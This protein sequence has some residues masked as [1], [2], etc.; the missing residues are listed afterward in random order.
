[1]R[2]FQAAGVPWCVATIACLLSMAASSQTAASHSLQQ[3]GWTIDY[4]PASASLSISAGGLGEVAQD[5]QF[6]EQTPS[7]LQRLTQFSAHVTG[8]HQ[9][10][11]RS[12]APVTTWIVNALPGKVIIST[13]SFHG[14]LRGWV[15]ASV[16]RTI[17]ILLDPRGEPV[18]WEGTEE[19]LTTYGGAVTSNLSY[20]PRLHPEVMHMALGQ[21]S[22]AGMHSL[23][24]RATDT[25][26]DFGPKVALQVSPNRKD[27]Y[28]LTIPVHGYA[29]IQLTPDY[30]TRILHVPFYVRYD[31]TYFPTAPAVWSSW[32]I[33]YEHATEQDIIR[34]TDWLA[35]NLRPYGFEYVVLDDG[36]D[37]TPYFGHPEK[38]DHVPPGETSGHAWIQN[39][40]T[41]RFTHGPQWLTSYIH[42]KGLKAGVWLVPNVY[43]LALKDH[44]DWYLYDKQGHVIRDYDTPALDSSNPQALDFLRHLFSTLDKFGFDYYKF[45]GESALPAYAPSVDRSRLYSPS[46][47]LVQA[48]RNRF[49]AIRQT[50][51]LKRFI[52]ECPA[53][54]PLNAIGFV[55][56]YFNGQDVFENW[57][58]MYPYFSSI[59]GN[60]FLNHMVTYVMPGE[61]MALSTLSTMVQA[62][63]TQSPSAVDALRARDESPNGF[64]TTLAEARTLV[65]YTS[66]TGVVYAVGDVMPDLP[67]DRVQLLRETMP[68]LPILPI[69]LFSRGTEKNVF[70]PVPGMVRT[71]H[72]PEVLDLKINASAGIYDVVAETNWGDKDVDRILSFSQLGLP[73]DSKFVVFDFWNQQP[74][75]VF[76]NQ[77][78][79]SIEP[80]DTRVLALHP[81]VQHPQLIGTSRHISGTYSVLSQGWDAAA[82]DL[83]GESKTIPSVLYTLWFYLPDGY[84]QSSVQVTSKKGK[85]VDARWQQQGNFGSLRFRGID[86]P[87]AWRIAF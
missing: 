74:L 23:F 86:E 13:T 28:A 42:A 30:F 47:D 49:A 76:S 80:H 20:L 3:N 62:A 14:V 24:D 72:F 33:Y 84:R 16:N 59:T 77:L 10:T 70:M 22:G 67:P 6:N 38:L 40:S 36:Y 54:T 87:V 55:N 81:I 73:L 56:S 41:T 79:L 64:G 11:L 17:A 83:Y 34:N 52:E 12:A 15:P 31:D 2:R 60:L 44:P 68:T 48:F 9:L 35:A 58:G 69:D 39:W 82:K 63:A 29:T 7:G 27:A 66:L 65:T 50:V 51:G 26:I 61:G 75:G 18:K 1:M 53:G 85:R 32:P 5:L 71:P 4:S 57:D 45:D 37:R 78:H 43:A 19:T 8:N 21:V 46:T 25:A